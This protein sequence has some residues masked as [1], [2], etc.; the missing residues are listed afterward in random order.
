MAVPAFLARKIDFLGITRTIEAVLE[1]M[2]VVDQPSLEQVIEADRESRRW[3]E[4]LI[5]RQAADR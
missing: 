3:A 2:S 1:K 4:E 5:A